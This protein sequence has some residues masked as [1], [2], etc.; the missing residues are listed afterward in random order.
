MDPT[1]RVHTDTI[2]R[3]WST[4]KNF[5]HRSN[6]ISKY[7]KY[8]LAIFVFMNNKGNESYEKLM[9][10][11]IYFLDFFMLVKYFFIYSNVDILSHLTP[12]N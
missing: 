3:T 4:I 7:L 5:I 2:K 11:L 8:Y 1:T 6:F 12:K 10:L 9:K